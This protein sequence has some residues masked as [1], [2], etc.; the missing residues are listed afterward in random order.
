MHSLWQDAEGEQWAQ[1]EA[2]DVL[3]AEAT[4]ARII[5]E[6]DFLMAYLRYM[7]IPGPG[8]DFELQMRPT[9]SCSNTRSLT[10][11]AGWGSNLCLLSNLSCCSWI[12]N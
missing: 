4:F 9:P 8:M 12:F 10:H 7:E 3:R 11:S 1:D 5:L 2:G 6:G